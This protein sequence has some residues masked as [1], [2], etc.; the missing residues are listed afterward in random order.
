MLARALVSD[1]PLS[2]LELETARRHFAELTKLLELSGPA[3]DQPLREAQRLNGQ[4]I[5]RLHGVDPRRGTRQPVE[6][7][8]LAVQ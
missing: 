7:E 1:G 3:F 6:D 2:K 5:A 4:A 8:R